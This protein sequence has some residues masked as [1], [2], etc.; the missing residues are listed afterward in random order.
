MKTNIFFSQGQPV[1]IDAPETTETL[2]KS[3]QIVIHLPTQLELKVCP[4]TLF[5]TPLSFR[6]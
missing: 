5:L 6:L 4:D 3:L 2:D 1:L